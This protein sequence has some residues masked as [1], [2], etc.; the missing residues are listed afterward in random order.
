MFRSTA[1]LVSLSGPERQLLHH[2]CWAPVKHFTECGMQTAV[3]CW[4]WLLAARPDNAL[5]VRMLH[6][7]EL[8]SVSLSTEVTMHVASKKNSY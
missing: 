4:D 7:V 8:F 2:L 3:A 1:L 5:Q 6:V